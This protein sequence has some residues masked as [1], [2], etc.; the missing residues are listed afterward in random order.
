MDYL[1][2]LEARKP[3]NVARLQMFYLKKKVKH[4]N[5]FKKKVSLALNQ[6]VKIVIKDPFKQRGFKARWSS[7]VYQIVKV[8]KNAIPTAYRVSSFGSRLFYE[9]ELNPVVEEER[10]A[11]SAVSRKILG[12]INDK[13]FAIRW[14][15]SGKPLEYEQKF[16]VQTNSE[17]TPHY[18]TESEIHSFDN[19]QQKLITYQDKK[20]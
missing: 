5:S 20:K 11:A 18:M 12:I 1:S 16:L 6:N 14:L 17:E 8:L 13:K 10:L 2:P 15:R 3:T 9:Q 7:K 19:G 4:A